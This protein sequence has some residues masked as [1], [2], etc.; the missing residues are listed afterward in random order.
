MQMGV[1]IQCL[2]TGLRFIL[3]NVLIGELS[4]K[5]CIASRWNGNC[6]ALDANERDTAEDINAVQGV[7]LGSQHVQCCIPEFWKRMKDQ[8]IQVFP[9]RKIGRVHRPTFF[10]DF[11]A[12]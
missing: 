9:P 5:M 4:G 8:T 10:P 3:K 6:V 1:I 2:L 12:V 7:I 11:I